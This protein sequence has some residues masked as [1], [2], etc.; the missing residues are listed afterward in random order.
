MQATVGAADPAA[1]V[2][3]GA[4]AVAVAKAQIHQIQTSPVSTTEV[5]D[6][7]AIVIVSARMIGPVL[8]SIMSLI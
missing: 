6:A 2:P 7:A 4:A 1:A 8:L 3:K 5:D